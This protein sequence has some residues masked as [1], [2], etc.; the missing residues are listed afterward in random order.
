MTATRP[1]P[2]LLVDDRPGNLTA[3]EALLG[4]LGLELT[5][6]LSGNEA[7]RLTL[8]QE[9]A[10]VL[11]D[12][13]MPDMD[14]FETAELLRANPKTRHLPIIFVTAGMKDDHYRFKGYE[15]GAVDYLLKPIEPLALRSKVLMFSDLY[16]Q[17]KDLE[18]RE[19]LLE[20]LVEQR[21]RALRESEAALRQVS[22]A[23]EQSP[24]IILITDLEGR[25]QYVNPKFT[26]VTGYTPEEAL[27]QNPRVLKSGELAPDLYADLW[28]TITAGQVWE[29]NFH[30][31]K[32]NGDLFWE[33]ATISPIRDENGAITSFVA[34]KEDTT[35]RRQAEAERLQW[36]RE[37]QHAQKLESLG[38]LAG[39]VAHD[40]NNV[41]AAVLGMASALKMKYAT[42]P[43]LC[44]SLDTILHASG[45]GRDLVKGLTDFSRK[46]VEEARSLDLNDLVQ[47][48]VDLLR[49][50][51][52]EKI[53]FVL[54]LAEDLPQ[55]L[56]EPSSLGNALMNVCVN[57]LHAMPRGGVLRL[58]TSSRNG[59]W[60]EL[61]IADTGGGMPPE[62]LARATDPFFTTKPFGQGTGLGLAIVHGTMKA[63][64]GRLE[65]KS[66]LGAGTTVL[67][68][69]PIHEGQ[70][71]E[72]TQ[73]YAAPT[74]GPARHVLL[75]DD[76]DLIL[77]GIPPMLR[78]LGHTVELASTAF[79]ALARIESP[80][81]PFD[82]VIMDHNM[83][84]LTGAA[85]LR[86][87]RAT[88]ATLPLVLATGFVDADVTALLQDLPGILLL[89]KPYSAKELEKIIQASQPEQT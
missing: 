15:A 9:F 39:G 48:E 49:R 23:V 67:L 13:Q 70:P 7:L 11:L 33:H 83:P 38:S 56:G 44:K 40:M 24:A 1:V 37:I 5:R 27:G 47:K 51:T 63:H 22:R 72:S 77:D 60:V 87:L 86:Q 4:D 6:A 54:E 55:I 73:P 35:F 50:T 57:A 84:G 10:L 75:V 14:G 79:E 16:Q 74:E 42:D 59:P 17:R 58:N 46:G 34:V 28:K 80:G 43:A 29:G 68:R 78:M 41:L 18:L 21:T 82:L 20:S 81:I 71:L 88:R 62:V 8:K 25:I 36:E 52:L 76:D 32:K 30:N 12:V 64:G 2:I 66:T 65:L 3:L 53:E 45:R 26:E 19:A 61:G 31:R 85:A 69:F 89:S